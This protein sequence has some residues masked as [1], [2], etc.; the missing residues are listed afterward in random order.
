MEKSNFW[1]AIGLSIDASKE[2]GVG[3]N[4]EEIL[5]TRPQ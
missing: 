5:T 3:I 1:E 4:V 2:V